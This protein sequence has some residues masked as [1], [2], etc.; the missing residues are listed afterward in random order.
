M[1]DESE[2]I[3]VIGELCISY[4]AKHNIKLTPSWKSGFHTRFHSDDNLVVIVIIVTQGI[5]SQVNGIVYTWISTFTN[6][7]D[8]SSEH[9]WR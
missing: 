7:S 5:E 8:S 2:E 6:P 9:S 1:F 4:V 3:Q